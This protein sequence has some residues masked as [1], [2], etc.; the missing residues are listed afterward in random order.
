MKD[1]ALAGVRIV[2]TQV[3][4]QVAQRAE[5]FRHAVGEVVMQLDDD[6]EVPVDV[7]EQLVCY[8]RKV[9]PGN[10]VGPAYRDVETGDCV[11]RIRTDL[12]GQMQSLYA[13]VLCGAPWGVARMGRATSIGVGYGVDWRHCGNEQAVKT[14]WLPGGCALCFRQDLVTEA[15]FP[16]TGK[17]YCEDNIH[18]LL[19]RQRGLQHWVVP[20]ARCSIE[21]PKEDFPDAAWRGTTRARHHYV[22]LSN[23]SRWRA[24]LYSACLRAR[25]FLLDKKKPS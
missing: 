25:W 14:D 12:Q 5:G 10:V 6:I 17:A 23:G 15:F 20:N 21:V 8:L 19:R 2:I 4:G 22:R 13:T 9:G 3:R 11:H 1:L 7:V 24:S 16:F 18:S